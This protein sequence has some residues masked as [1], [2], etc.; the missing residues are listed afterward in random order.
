MLVIITV[1]RLDNDR[2]TIRVARPQHD[3]NPMHEYSSEKE[4][5]DVLV[6]FGISERTNSSSAEIA[7]TDGYRRTIK[8]PSDGYSTE[9]IAV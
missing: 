8:I 4:V 7:G 2:V 9:P 5:R 3:S 1:S 6:D